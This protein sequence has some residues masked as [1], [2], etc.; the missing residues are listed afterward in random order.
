MPNGEVSALASAVVQWPNVH[1]DDV[2]QVL[3]QVPQ[4]SGSLARS[5]HAGVPVLVHIV[6]PSRTRSSTYRR[7]GRRGAGEGPARAEGELARARGEVE[8]GAVADLRAIHDAVAAVLAARRHEGAARAAREGSRRAAPRGR[9]GRW[10]PR[11]PPVALFAALANAVSARGPS[12]PP[13]LPRTRPAPLLRN[14]SG[15]AFRRR[16]EGRRLALARLRR[17]SESAGAA[18]VQVASGAVASGPPV[19]ASTDVVSMLA[20]SRR[21]R[22]PGR[23][24]HRR[25]DPRRRRRP[26]RAGCG[27][28][29]SSQRPRTGSTPK[30][31][32]F[33]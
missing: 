22:R 6:R 11:G 25:P 28:R 19:A 10:R 17:R 16:V 2:P 15:A 23:P 8:R 7:S 3:P 32:M 4:L 14:A 29:R 9:S 27:P 18:S 20:A 30:G 26:R 31:G 13:R 24:R 21:A 12:R 5:M 33:A 1:A